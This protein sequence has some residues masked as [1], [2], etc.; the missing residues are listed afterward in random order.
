MR[1]R[2]PGGRTPSRRGPGRPGAGSGRPR[3]CGRSLGPSQEPLAALLVEGAARQ[4]Q[5]RLE[6]LVLAEDDAPALAESAATA[7]R[8]RAHGEEGASD[9]A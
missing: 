8:E 3:P 4:V 1:A 2:A 9:A 5:A 7:V 6:L